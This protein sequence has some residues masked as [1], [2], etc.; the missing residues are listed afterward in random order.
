[1][2]SARVTGSQSLSCCF[3]TMFFLCLSSFNVSADNPIIERDFWGVLYKKGGKTFYCN[4]PFSKKS[5]LLSES[6][7]YSS[8]WIRDF[9]DCGTKRQCERTSKKYNEITADLHNIVPSDAYFAFKR[10]NSFFGPL[11][12]TVIANECGIRKKNHLIEPPNA[13]KGDISRILLYMHK[14]YGLPLNTSL[15]VLKIWNEIDPPDA[16]EKARDSAIKA[17]QGNSNPFIEDP[18]L[19]N[20]VKP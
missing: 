17:I 1:M 15:S 7:V 4:K 19:I 16:K 14:R 11:D 3:I 10:K 20:T 8:I 9:L 5:P 6:Y 18:S 12:S 13:I 2:S